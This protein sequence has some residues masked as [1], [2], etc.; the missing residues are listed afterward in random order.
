[1]YC[2]TS[3]R[4]KREHA[5]GRGGRSSLGADHRQQRPAHRTS[6]TDVVRRS[7]FH[8]VL[9]FADAFTAAAA[10]RL[11]TKPDEW[12]VN[13]SSVRPYLLDLG[14]VNGTFLNGERLEAT[15]YY[16]LMEKDVI[17]FGLS[18]R[19]FVLLHDKSVGD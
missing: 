1:M 18:S 13:T 5:R 2:G 6:L 19:E 10:A 3:Q 9:T 16:E 11:V 15:R 14:S 8:L 17:K 7:S 4:R 12:G